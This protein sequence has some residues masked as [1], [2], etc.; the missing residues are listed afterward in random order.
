MQTRRHRQVLNDLHFNLKA[1]DLLLEFELPPRLDQSQEP[2]KD[3]KTADQLQCPARYP[4]W[5]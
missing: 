5:I 2:T 1:S 3:G 4:N